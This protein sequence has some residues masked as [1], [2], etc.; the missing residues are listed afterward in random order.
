MVYHEPNFREEGKHGHFLGRRAG[1]TEHAA[2]FLKFRFWGWCRKAAQ[3][4]PAKL[5]M[6]HP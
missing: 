6:A 2:V 3:Y 5:G 4:P 1:M